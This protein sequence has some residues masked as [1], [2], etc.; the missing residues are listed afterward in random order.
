MHRLGPL[1]DEIDAV[2]DRIV[3]LLGVRQGIVRRVAAIKDADDIPVVL[4]DRIEAVK[5]R[6]AANG[7]A[8]GLDPDF[9]RRLYQLIIDEACAVETRAMAPAN[10]AGAG[11]PAKTTDT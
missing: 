9:I 1:R 6:N 7:A 4:A 3:E 8:L 11:V 5:D 10:G 2:D